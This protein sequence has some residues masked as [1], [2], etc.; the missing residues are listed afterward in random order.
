MSS[1]VEKLEIQHV[2]AASID[3]MTSNPMLALGTNTLARVS[4]GQQEV[5]SVCDGLCLDH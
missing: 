1:A 3:P 4:W 5:P 2:K